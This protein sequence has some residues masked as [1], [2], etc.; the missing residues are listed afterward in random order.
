MTIKGARRSGQPPYS[1]KIT[2]P[3]SWFVLHWTQKHLM[4]IGFKI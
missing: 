2:K 3:A 4:R 1:F